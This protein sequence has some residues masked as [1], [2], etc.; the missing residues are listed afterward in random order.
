MLDLGGLF[1]AHG[2]ARDT[3]GDG[4]A[5]VIAARIVLPTPDQ[6]GQ[7]AAA[8]IAARLGYETT[9][10]SFPLVLRDGDRDRRRWPCRSGRAIGSCAS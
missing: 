3:N 4:L 7:L 5:D 9:A 1:G 6:R 2:F 8:N 10:L